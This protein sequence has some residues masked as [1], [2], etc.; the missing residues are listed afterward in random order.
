MERLLHFLSFSILLKP[1]DNKRKGRKRGKVLE[2][3][4]KERE[5]EGEKE[6]TVPFSML[7]GLRRV[8]ML[9]ILT[10]N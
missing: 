2:R 8:F 1:Q 3:K 10:H 6:G 4:E 5:R 9:V 7:Y